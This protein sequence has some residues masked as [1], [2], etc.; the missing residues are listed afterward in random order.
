MESKRMRR[1]RHLRLLGHE[2]WGE[3]EGDHLEDLGVDGWIILRW[4]FRKWV[5]GGHELDCFGSE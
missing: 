5:G 2:R 4:V 3:L 1:A